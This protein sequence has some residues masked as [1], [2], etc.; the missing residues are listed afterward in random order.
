MKNDFITEIATLNEKTNN[1]KKNI[2]NSIK[3]Y[4]SQH[5]IK[6]FRIG[7]MDDENAGEEYH[8]L[9][10]DTED[11]GIGCFNCVADTYTI[12]DYII[13]KEDGSIYVKCTY[14][15]D[16]YDFEYEDYNEANMMCY[17]DIEILNQIYLIIQNEKFH[18]MNELLNQRYTN[19]K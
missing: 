6:S 4:M 18:R 3:D 7:F 5:N 1:L 8:S 13:M 11:F 12:L 2:I 14:C 9:F 10:L 15:R 17:M 19:H 16:G